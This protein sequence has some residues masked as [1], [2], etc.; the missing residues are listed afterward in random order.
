MAVSLPF[1]DLLCRVLLVLVAAEML[2]KL[3]LPMTQR[4]LSRLPTGCVRGFC[5]WPLSADR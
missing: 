4:G 3:S 1:T 2:E 5:S